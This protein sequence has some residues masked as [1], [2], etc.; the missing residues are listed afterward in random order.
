MIWSTY[1]PVCW[2]SNPS[3]NFWPPVWFTYSEGHGA[4]TVK[5][6][7]SWD[8]RGIIWVSF[9]W[10]NDLGCHWNSDGNRM[11][12]VT[13]LK[14]ESSG[15]FHRI[16]HQQARFSQ[17]FHCPGSQTWPAGK[18]APISS[19]GFPSRPCLMAAW[20][21]SPQKAIGLQM[22]FMTFY[23]QALPFQASFSRVKF[24]DRRG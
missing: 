5:Y 15:V 7:E 18:S 2:D 4:N 16:C 23:D 8:T 20:Y 17:N 24:E 14:S 22:G 19:L 6:S 12:L 10:K 9:E 13:I 3:T 21:L 1:P 11:E